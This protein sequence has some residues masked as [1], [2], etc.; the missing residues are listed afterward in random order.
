MYMKPSL[1]SVVIPVFNGQK[2]LTECLESICDQDH[3]SYEIVVVDNN[4]T[5]D[6]KAIIQSFQGRNKK[7]KYVFEPIRRRGA[8]RYTGEQQVAGD[9]VLMTD[10]DCIVATDWISQMVAPI[11]RGEEIAV[12]GMANPVNEKDYWIQQYQQERK[13]IMYERIQDKKIGLLDTANFAIKTDVL[14][15][16]GYTN[17]HMIYANDVELQVRLLLSGHHLCFLPVA[18]KHHHLAW[19]WGLIR[20]MMVRGREDRLVRK[21]YRDHEHLFIP[22][23][24]KQEILFFESLLREWK[25]KKLEVKYVLVSGLGW[26]LGRLLGSF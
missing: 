5:D 10:A 2:T 16:I 1:V 23:E 13:R 18:V 17:P 4:S 22:W 6:T 9:V 15:E 26:R 24:W 25:E 11:L 20:K 3:A 8:A 14:R 7:I 12:Q 21:M 19:S